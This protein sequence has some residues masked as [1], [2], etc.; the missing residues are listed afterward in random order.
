MDYLGE[1]GIGAWSYG[2]PEQAEIAKQMTG[3]MLN[4][5]FIHQLFTGMAKA[6]M[7]WVRC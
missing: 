4:S 7:S 5:Q 6:W 1:S 3:K 2:T